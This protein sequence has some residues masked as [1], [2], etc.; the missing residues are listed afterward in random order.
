MLRRIILRRMMRRTKKQGGFMQQNKTVSLVLGG[1]GAR[2]LA[3]IGVIEWLTE[4][5]YEIRSIA[6]SSMGALVGGIY[7]A[8]KLDV[9]K[10]WVTALARGDVLRLLDPN[11]GLSGLFKGGMRIIETLRGLLGERNIWICRSPSPQWPPT[12]KSRRRCG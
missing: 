10:H 3:H 2:G 7:A 8:G 12:W 4:N 1:G 6:G 11:M 5:G 9:Y